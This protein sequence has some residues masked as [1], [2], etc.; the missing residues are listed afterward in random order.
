MDEFSSWFNSS[1]PSMFN[2]SWTYLTLA[3]AYVGS[4]ALTEN[5]SK[6]FVLVYTD[7]MPESTKQQYDE[8][9]Q[10]RVDEYQHANA[11]RK[12][13]ILR[14]NVGKKHFDIEIWDFTLNGEIKTGEGDQMTDSSGSGKPQ[15]PPVDKKSF[16]ITNPKNEGLNE[17]HSLSVKQEEPFSIG[18]N[19]SGASVIISQKKDGSWIKINGNEIRNYYSISKQ[20]NSAKI[21]FLESGDYKIMVRG[22]HGSDERYV[23]V[24][25][26]FMK[27]LLPI[28]LI[29][30]A[31]VG[32]VFAYQKLFKKADSW[33]DNDGGRNPN[34]S[35]NNT[36]S[37]DDW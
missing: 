9:D 28:L 15:T 11:M 14:K 3:H 13:G 1:F 2:D 35:M 22:E 25:S 24:S 5:I 12:L 20:A 21:T 19:E 34:N 17:K 27:L 18:W 7:G 36:S 29:L 6:A 37:N 10:R 31:V 16:R 30:L 33:D 26:D 32:A 8:I 23:S 4:V